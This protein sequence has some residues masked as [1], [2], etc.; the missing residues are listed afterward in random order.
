MS[1]ARRW[2][3]PVGLA[4]TAVVV[5]AANA[6]AHSDDTQVDLSAANRFTLTD[7]TKEILDAVDSKVE[8][9]VF[10]NLEGGAARDA[11]FL[12]ARYQERSGHLD[13]R[14]VDP[15]TRPGEARRLGVTDYS[16]VVLEYRG[17]R[18]DAPSVDEVQLSSAIL[19]LLR[20]E[21]RT[22]CVLVGH[23]EAALD[24][25]SQTGLS[26]FGQALEHNAYEPRELDLAREGDVPDECDVV[27]LA[28][29]RVPLLEREIEA[30]LDYG[31]A[32]G[33]LFVTVWP[34]TE[35]PVDVNPLL[36]E[37]GIAFFGGLVVDELR[38]EGF[39]VAN[40]IIESFP[41]A[42]PI[43]ENVHRLSFPFAGALVEVD[44]P[45]EGLSVSR[46]AET[47]EASFAETN[48]D[49]IAPGPGDLV[50]P[51][52]VAAAA[53]DS[54]V[55]EEAEERLGGRRPGIVRTRVFAA[56]TT[57]WV[58]NRFLNELGNRRFALNALAWLAEEEQ[59]LTSPELVDDVRSLPWT[60]ERQRLVVAV[61]VVLVP[62]LV[63]A[64]GG[65]V[66]LVV[67]RRERR[68]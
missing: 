30:L 49:E 12:L 40:L 47:S 24:D 11:R 46:L 36:Q 2:R 39:D 62:G 20:G 16:T 45:S 35:E 21:T 64:V 59:I 55:E 38:S 52:L 32:G 51:V 63:L 57:S 48:P 53:D 56:G 8:I 27:I 14:L 61:A 43:V 50:G 22:A 3:R 67:R 9:S 6:W 29:P 4:V 60:P 33:R 26:A 23:G 44:D 42:N 28:G 31:R 58:T 41:T 37:W 1:R 17:R 54:R 13:Y 7:E 10:L 66:W 18:V 68:S 15:D 65:G 34:F 25:D 19:R 5:V